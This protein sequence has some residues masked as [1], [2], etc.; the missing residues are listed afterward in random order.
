ML[1]I[2]TYSPTSHKVKSVVYGA[3]GAGKTY[4]A[5]TAPKPIFASAEAGL[6]STTNTGNKIDYVEIKTVDD[7]KDLLMYLRDEKHKYE[8]VVIDSITE[9][10]ELIKEEIERKK[11][12]PMSLPDWG[13]LSKSL[14]GIFKSFRDLD[15]H[16]IFIAQEQSEK[17]DTVTEKIVP[18]LNGKSATGIAYYMDVVGYAYITKDKKYKVTTISNDKLLT[19]D[20]SGVIAGSESET[21]QD[22]I[23]LVSSIEVKEEKVKEFKTLRDEIKG[24]S[25]KNDLDKNLTK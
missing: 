23:D 13:V 7:L 20:R 22:W 25:L 16:V 10:N 24:E 4:F 2:K 15:M 9:I 6:L 17:D 5:A 1:K 21:F 3:S 8:T 18:S 11:G 14:K 12:K 19:K